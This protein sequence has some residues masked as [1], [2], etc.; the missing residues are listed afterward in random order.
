MKDMDIKMQV[1]FLAGS[2]TVDE[3]GEEI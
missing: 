1:V 3:V 2:A